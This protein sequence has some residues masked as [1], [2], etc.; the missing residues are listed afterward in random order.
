[1]E[2]GADF[3]VELGTEELPPTEL[4]NLRD[5]FV[6]AIDDG[7]NDLQ[8]AHG[9]ITGFATPRRLAVTVAA[10]APR[11]PEQQVERRGPSVSAA[12]DAEGRPTRAAEGF[13]RSCGTTVAELRTLETGKGTWLV[14]RARQPGAETRTLLP[15]LITEAVHGL[16]V[17]RHMRWGEGDESFVR[18]VHWLVALLDGEVIDLELFGIRAD[19]LTFGHRFHHPAP[20]HL[21]GP[22]TY[23]AELCESGYV[24]ADLDQRREKI[25]AQVQQAARDI[26]GEALIDPELLQEV[27]GLVEWPVALAGHFEERFLALPREVLIAT[28]EGH[29]RYFP[30]ADTADALLPAFVTVANIDSTR[31]ELVRVGNERVVRPRLADALFFWEQDRRQP[32]AAYAAE[33]EHLAFQQ[34]LGSMA[35]KSG[36]LRMLAAMIAPQIGTDANLAERAAMLAKADLVT[37][38]VCEFTELQGVMGRYYAAASGEKTEVAIAIEEHYLPRHAGDALPRTPLGQALALA[39]RLDTLAG[40][41]AIGQRPTGEGDPFGLRR[42][43]LGIIR[44]L[45]EQ[46]LDLDVNALIAAA[47]AEQPVAGDRDAIGAQ[48]KE[49]LIERLRSYYSAAGVPAEVFAAVAATG[50]ARLLDFDRRIAAVRHFLTLPQA[51]NLAAAH[52]RVRNILRRTDE[53]TA[54]TVAATD[55]REEAEHELYRRTRELDADIAAR[56]TRGDY[57]GA[58]QALATLQAPVDRFFDDVLV[59]SDDPAERR[60]R[61]ALLGELDRLCRAVADISWL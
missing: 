27:A 41:F 47:V 39:D 53:P 60:N 8:I 10:V 36:R 35:D 32:L 11:Q 13:A 49:F 50:V 26:G 15:A 44:I 54:P 25:R 57:Q 28:L 21:A 22:D 29:Q 16:P 33:L 23:A 56:A 4:R 34:G 20:I 45:V 19:R 52:K 46:R 61:L 42:A 55:L 14:Y 31:P 18:P 37:G 2:T 6:R 1:M 12:F 5:A 51:A 3:L 17:S 7:L 9:A 59:M 43:A 38:M 24:I 40:I 48:V 30:V 58:L